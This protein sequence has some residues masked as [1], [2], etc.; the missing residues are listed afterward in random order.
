MI[1]PNSK[2][3]EKMTLKEL[4]K[5][6]EL[7]PTTVSRALN[8]FPEVSEKTRIKVMAAAKT[9]GYS[10]NARAQSLATGRTMAI[11][12]VIPTASE[13]EVVN[14]VF[15]DFIA[16]AGEVY[17]QEGYDTLISIVPEADQEQ[18]YE[19]IRARG[20]VDGV[21]VHAPRKGDKRVSMLKRV[22]IPFVVHGRASMEDDTYSWVDMNNQRAFERATA[23]LLDLGHRRI[24]FINGLEDMDFAVRRRAGFEAAHTARGLTPDTEIMFSGEMNEF[25]GHDIAAELLASDTPPTAFVVSSMISAIGVRRAIRDADLEMGKDVSVVIHD[26][27]LSYLPNGRKEPIFTATRSSVREAGQ[28]SARMLIEMIETR[29]FTPRHDL[30][31]ADLILGS[32]T[33]PAPLA[34]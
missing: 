4:A 23:L 33:G 14:P 30:L 15:A 3:F 1:N 32:S 13:H 27:D 11:G 20:S 16:G 28:R 19:R 12:H 21:I 34:Q 2:R 7:S 10:P 24:A 6:L 9:Y 5:L 18:A 22:G 25:Q 8:G 31:E 26:D 17:S 29:D